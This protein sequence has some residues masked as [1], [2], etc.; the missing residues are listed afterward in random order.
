MARI[1]YKDGFPVPR[2]YEGITLFPFG[3]YIRLRWRHN[4]VLINHEKIHWQQQKEC[5]CIFFYI[6]YGAMYL[7]NL[8]KY[9]NHSDAYRN[10]PFEREANRHECNM[11]YL[12]K[13]PKFNWIRWKIV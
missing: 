2:G 6:L 9:R 4:K 10:I 13:R 1:R 12:A 5:L 11:S 7:I 3:I 8:V